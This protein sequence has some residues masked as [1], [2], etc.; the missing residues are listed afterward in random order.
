[1]LQGEGGVGWVIR[2]GLGTFKDQLISVGSLF[3]ISGNPLEP[4]SMSAADNQ[5]K[6]RMEEETNACPRTCT[7]EVA[8]DFAAILNHTAPRRGH[9]RLLQEAVA[10]DGHTEGT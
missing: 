9:G 3:V 4:G 5:G 2:G 1:M 8:V 7:S 6:R 10:H